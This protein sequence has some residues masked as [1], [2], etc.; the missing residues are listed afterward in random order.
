MIPTSVALPRC[1]A[2]TAQRPQAH[3]RFKTFSACVFFLPTWQPKPGEPCTGPARAFWSRL[4]P[5]HDR[6]FANSCI[7]L[8]HHWAV[9]A[10]LCKVSAEQVVFLPA[11][12]LP[13]P[14]RC[15]RNFD[16]AIRQTALLPARNSTLPLF[17]KRANALLSPR[18]LDS[19]VSPD[20]LHGRRYSP[21]VASRPCRVLTAAALPLPLFPGLMVAA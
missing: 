3:S 12:C 11:S 17:S 8:L 4:E 14:C 10:T 20:A 5:N 1:C 18:R 6:L 16:F 9:S 19:R 15:S 2:S 13:N 7:R 21:A